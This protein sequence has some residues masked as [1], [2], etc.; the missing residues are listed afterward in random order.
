M[1]NRF[2]F[3]LF[4][5]FTLAWG[6]SVTQSQAQWCTPTHSF[7]C[8]T[9]DYI[10]QFTLGGNTY[11]S[12]CSAGNYSL[13]T[14]PV[15][16]FGRSYPFTITI[17][18]AELQHVGMWVD[19]DNSQSFYEVVHEN[20]FPYASTTA[21][22]SFSGNL[23]TNYSSLRTTGG[24]TRMRL[25]T[26]YYTAGPW[27]ETYGIN[28]DEQ[29]CKPRTYGETEDY[30]VY[31]APYP[32]QIVAGN[33]TVCYNGN[34]NNIA[35]SADGLGGTFQWYYKN[36]LTGAPKTLD[37]IGSW[38]AIPG[39]T[40]S[41]FDPPAPIIGSRTYACFVTQFGQPFSAQAGIWA[42]GCRQVDVL[43][44]V[45]Y[46]TIASGD[47][48]FCNSGNPSPINLSSFPKGSGGYQWRWYWRENATGACP[49]GAATAGWATNS[50][51]ANVTGTTQ[52]GG[53]ITFDP[54]SAGAVGAGRTFSVLITPVAFGSIPACGVPRWVNNCRK[55]VVNSCTSFSPGTIAA[56]N[57]T[58]CNAADPADIAF[59]I[60]PT[61][62]STYQWYYQN[63][64]VAAPANAAST[65]G[66]IGMGSLSTFQTLNPPELFTST[67]YAC[68]VTNGASSQWATGVRQI[69]V[70]PAFQPG[71]IASGDQSLCANGN[72]A[73]ISL[74]ALPVGS[75]SYTYQWYYKN[76]VVACPSGN[77]T[78]GWIAVSGGT[79]TSYDP[80]SASTTGRTFSLRVTP[81]GTPTCGTPSFTTSCRKITVVPSPCSNARIGISEEEPDDL[82]GFEPAAS[83][84]QNI[85]NP[86]NNET[87]V[88]CFVP[89]G[90][91]S[92]SIR[93]N[94]LD[95]RM[96]EELVLSETGHHD[97]VI[98]KGKLS[99]G[100]YIYS[101]VTDGQVQAIRKL[102]ISQ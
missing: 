16:Y 98:S 74:S 86:F 81:G 23:V 5:F 17:G 97:V 9:G 50:T 70:L 38:I 12:T 33:Q 52:S 44:P 65:A 57:Q 22:T 4:S 41:S 66:W 59:S 78:S 49:T 18:T 72:P 102:V 48:T 79:S 2:R 37:P 91:R 62:G 10:S 89:K 40:T 76:A 46:G 83:L 32:G 99:P 25:R 92:T 42:E 51:S 14:G 67:T 53:G 64:I 82:L 84:S 96:V 19:Y 93:V 47:E 31:L 68:R 7:A 13:T 45:D 3:L 27:V 58:I 61:A 26:T 43:P 75:G 21:G 36:G 29:S 100:V 39:A 88:S 15:L 28:F 73:L 101:L 11:N 95:G 60:P 77:S 8:T 94:A 20:E 1:K 87:S 85:P 55:T 80:Q 6:A 54:G 71:T 69:T 90:F 56:G 35:I 24:W 63:G 30:N 34:P